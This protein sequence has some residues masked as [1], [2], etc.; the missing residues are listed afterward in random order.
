MFY[1]IITS[2]LKTGLALFFLIRK[3]VKR[4]LTS[5]IINDSMSSLAGTCENI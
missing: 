1:E 3:V 4:V 5:F 2:I